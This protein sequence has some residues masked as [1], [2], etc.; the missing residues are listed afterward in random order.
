ME[1]SEHFHPCM[2]KLIPGRPNGRRHSTQLCR[3][4]VVTNLSDAY[5]MTIKY[6][7]WSNHD[8]RAPVTARPATDVIA[9]SSRTFQ[10]LYQVAFEGDFEGSWA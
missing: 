2:Q 6:G 4:S 3:Y 8:L 5:C 9:V 10:V 7:A 1:A